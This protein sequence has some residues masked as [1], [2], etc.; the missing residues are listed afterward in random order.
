MFVFLLCSGSENLRYCPPP[1][2]KTPKKHHPFLITLIPKSETATRLDQGLVSTS[3]KL[4]RSLACLYVARNFFFFLSSRFSTSKPKSPPTPFK[5]LI[6]VPEQRD[7]YRPPQSGLPIGVSNVLLVNFV[8]TT[9]VPSLP[10][11]ASITPPSNSPFHRTTSTGGDVK[12]FWTNPRL[13][14]S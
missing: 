13:S 1:T 7:P 9:H 10:T 8:H 2:T 3:L 12:L 14:P 5:F 4:R 6:T 11:T